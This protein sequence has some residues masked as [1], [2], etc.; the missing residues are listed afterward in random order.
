[1][2]RAPPEGEQ[3]EQKETKESNQEYNTLHHSRSIDD[4]SD[5]ITVLSAPHDVDL[6][7]VRCAYAS[8]PDQRGG[9]GT[10]LLRK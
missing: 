6:E 5:H 10:V 9:A 8:V 1:M 3:N 7:G 4:N 2:Q